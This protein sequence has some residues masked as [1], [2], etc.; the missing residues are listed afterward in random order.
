MPDRGRPIEFGANVDPLAAAPDVAL[1][2]TRIADRAGLE[3][4]AIQDHPYN[5]THLD[6]WTLL[7]TLAVRTE[8]VRFVTDVANLPLRPPAMLAKAA[9]TLDVLTGGRVEL[10]LGAGAFWDAIRA[11]GGPARGPREAV[12]ALDE[13]LQ[14]MRLLWS[15]G[16]GL[17]F[18]GAHYRLEGAQGGPVPAH[19]IGIWLGALGPRMLAL[20]GRV[21]DGVI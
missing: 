1:A 3:L 18:D 16:R 20:T 10:G 13:A 5:R 7:A 19:P 4:V 12:D 9:A 14:I 11:F 17:R 6:T 2:I 21:A 15:G 8:R